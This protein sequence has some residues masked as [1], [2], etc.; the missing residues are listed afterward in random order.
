MSYIETDS[1]R[2]C[3]KGGQTDRQT[4]EQLLVSLQEVSM[5]L[6]VCQLVCVCLSVCQLVSL[7]ISCPNVQHHD[8][9]AFLPIS[10]NFS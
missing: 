2:I 7:S 9:H 1:S 3:L 4:S 10:T 5:Y 6:S 8:A